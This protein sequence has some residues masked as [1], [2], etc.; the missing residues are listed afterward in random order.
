MATRIRDVN[1][2]FYGI[3]PISAFDQQRTFAPGKFPLKKVFD[4]IRARDPAEDSYRIS[5]T[6]L[7]GETLCLLH[8][9]GPKP[10][11]GAYYRD[12]LA[13]PLTEYKGQIAEIMMRDGEAPVNAAYAAFFPDDVVGLLR[14]SSASPS[15]AK[16]GLWLRCIGGYACGL[17]SLT[18]ADTLA[19]LQDHPMGIRR[20]SVRCRRALL[21][22]VETHAPL[23]AE[24][25]RKVGDLNQESDQ[26]GVEIWAGQYGQDR[27]SQLALQE[28]QE[29]VWATPAL[30]QALVR[31]SGRKKPINLKRDRI[32]SPVKVILQDKKQVG[33]PEAADVLF[34]AYQQE[35][36]SIRKAVAIMRGLANDPPLA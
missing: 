36:A 22:E 32:S 17:L 19:Q 1:V 33:L 35:Q 16:I 29:L 23:V 11:L 21:G 13:R 14:T 2:S 26:M 5:D 28:L 9:N 27:F 20:L 31:V 8:E 25:L 18:D 10:I 3:E 34:N 12:N 24:A 30:E 7:G 6:L 4:T 15:F